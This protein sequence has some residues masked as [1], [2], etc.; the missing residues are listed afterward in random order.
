MQIGAMLCL[1]AAF[2][3]TGTLQAR[4]QDEPASTNC[5]TSPGD[6]TGTPIAAD[7]A[8]MA[9]TPIV[10][11]SIDRQEQSGGDSSSH[12][13]L[14]VVPNYLTVE[15]R[16]DV[17]PIGARQKFKLVSEDAFDVF[18]YPYIG[19]IAL[20]S[21][22]YGATKS[23]YL[24]QY[25]ASWTDITVGNFM[26]SAV[27]PSVLHQDPR[28]FER[29]S[30]GMISRVGYAASRSF[31]TQSDRGHA[32]LNIS[33]LGGNMAAAGFSNVYYPRAQRTL[34]ATASRWATQMLWDTL[35]SEAKEFWPDVRHKFHGAGR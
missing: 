29:G 5:S 16:S 1:C 22:N 4:T 34:S 11:D 23:G 10:A 12:H 3:T 2:V 15:H 32:Q 28:Y 8:P 33:E 20:F 30:G 31:I 9:D 14:G 6:E 27:L 18:N 7:L 25:A 24:K 19:V 35:A 21:R 26:T 13:I 17:T